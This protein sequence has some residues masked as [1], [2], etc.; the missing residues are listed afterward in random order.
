MNRILIVDDNRQ[1]LNTMRMFLSRFGEEVDV[2]TADGG[3]TAIQIL[4]EEQVDLVITDLVMPGVDG[5][6]LLAHINE[7]HPRT[8]CIAMTGFATENVVR[9]LPNSLLYFMRKPFKLNE[10]LDTVRKSLKEKPPGGTV[11]GISI[12]SFLKLIEMDEKSCALDVVLED[13]RKGTF[14]F[15]EGVL[16]DAVFGNLFG[17]EAALEMIMIE[18]RMVFTFRPL[19]HHNM[20]RRIKSRIMD[21]MITAAYLQ[22]QDAF[23]PI[24]HSTG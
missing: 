17:K 23:I 9:M 14:F 2:M 13:N 1:A 6:S 16:L 3:E 7:H 12:S 22:D 5:L 11:G 19:S 4:K 8:L 18:S 10:L 24:E 21:L 20:I 15:R